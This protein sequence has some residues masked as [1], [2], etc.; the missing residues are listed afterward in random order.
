MPG[1]ALRT[2]LIVLFLLVTLIG[3]HRENL[4]N[5]VKIWQDAVNRHDLDAMGA[6]LADSAVFEIRDGF[7]VQGKKAIRAVQDNDVGLNTRM[8][9][10]DCLTRGNLQSARV[11]SAT[12]I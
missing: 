9:F 3:C 6:M 5:R 8:E 1:K 12:T 4:V 2:K 7:S 11:W 10:T